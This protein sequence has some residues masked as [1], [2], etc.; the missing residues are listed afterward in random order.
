MIK[1]YLVRH[2]KTSWNEKGIAQGHTD[3][4]LSENGIK[5]ANELAKLIDINSID[6]CLSSPL[7]R[8]KKTAEII[9]D[10]KIDILCDDLLIERNLGDFEGKRVTLEK[11]RSHWNLRDVENPDHMETVEELMDRTKKFI[12]KIKKEYD[13]KTILVV[14]H[15]C[16]IKGIHFNLLGYDDNTDFLSFYPENTTLYE[17]DI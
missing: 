4:E 9:T 15:A 14:T 17:Y 1:L 5:A 2:G 6:V 7:L 16:V 11:V 3:I 10:N 13:N 12:D 8:A